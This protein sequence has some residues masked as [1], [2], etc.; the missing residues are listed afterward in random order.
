MRKRVLWCLTGSG[1]FIHECST[2]IAKLTRSGVEVDVCLSRAGEEVSRLYGVLSDF[3]ALGVRVLLDR[4]SSGL[5][6]AGRVASGRYG[7]VVVAPATSNTVAKI[8]LGVADTPPTIA[9]SQALKNRIPVAILPSDYGDTVVTTYPCIVHRELCNGCMICASLCPYEAI[10]VAGSRA[11]I[12]YSRCVGCGI[13]A[14]V[15]PR[16]AVK[17]WSR[18]IYSCY[19]RDVAYLRN[20]ERL[21]VKVFTSVESLLEFILKTVR[22]QQS[23]A[24][25]R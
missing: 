9:V 14:T 25:S 7:V 5:D 15:C 1:S 20:L 12:D 4:S 19:A 3:L 2:S 6:V 11:R 22:A 23:P 21:G 24:S 10:T 8:V 13:C 16:G 18:T 17:C